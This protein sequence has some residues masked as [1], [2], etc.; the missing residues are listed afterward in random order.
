MAVKEFKLE[1]SKNSSAFEHGLTTDSK[2]RDSF[3]LWN[4]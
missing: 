2:C 1:T 3:L 4:L